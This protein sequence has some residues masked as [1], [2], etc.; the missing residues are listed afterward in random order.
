MRMTV[1]EGAGRLLAHASALPYSRPAVAAKYCVRSAASSSLAEACRRWK[2]A[3]QKPAQA[4]R[5]AIVA[6][7]KDPDAAIEPLGKGHRIGYL[8]GWLGEATD[9]RVKKR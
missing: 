2:A 5:R 8:I 9:K 6:L 7:G 3:L 4:A 1:D